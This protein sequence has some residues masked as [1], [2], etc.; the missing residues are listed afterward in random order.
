M[1][2]VHYQR[3]ATIAAI[4]TAAGNGA[5]AI[6]RLS[7][8]DAVQIAS[9]VFSGPVALYHSHTAHTGEILAA[10]G[11]IIDQ[12]L[13]I[14]FRSPRSYTGEDSVEIH[15][16]GGAFVT[17]AVLERVLQ[18][19]ALLALPGEFSFRAYINGKLDLAQAE[20]VQMLITA[21]NSLAQQSAARQLE[22][23]LSKKIQ[24][25]QQELTQIAANLEAWIDFPE[26]DLAFSSK[27]EMAMQLSSIAG[28]MHQLVSTFHEGKI[29]HHGI[30]LCLI[31]PP[32]VG[33]SSLMNVLLKKNRAIVTD[34]PGTTRDLLEEELC[35]GSLHFRLIDTAGITETSD[36]V[37]REG[38]S[39]SRAAIESADLILLILDASRP[40]SETDYELIG[41]VAPEKAIIIWNKI[42]LVPAPFTPSIAQSLDINNAVFLSTKN[43]IGLD[44]LK[45]TIEEKIWKRGLPSHEEAMISSQRHCQILKEAIEFCETARWGLLENQS[46]ELISIDMRSCLEQLGAITGTNISEE[47][48]TSIFTQFCIGK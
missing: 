8:K 40:L 3:D 43:E 31:G 17:C 30:S 22:G 39:R 28:K 13:L 26:E 4:A 19:G 11:S 32:N 2:S 45:K 36:P 42:D 38:V 14:V 20:A 12:V 25:F 44:R 7:G 9:V 6:V 18:A 35:L 47:I 23:A 48:L 34:I 1:H 5:I 33:K 29:V 16:H 37:E 21:K 46:P 27:E 10:D 41:T 15:C 24:Q